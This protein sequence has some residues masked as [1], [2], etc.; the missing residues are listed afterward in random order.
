MAKLD[1]LIV[2]F[3]NN[4]KELDG[5]KKICDSQNANIKELMQADGLSEYVTGDYVARCTISKRESINEDKLLELSNE[6]IALKEA[7]KTKEYI[8]MDILEELIYAGK[9][10]NETLIAM[11][12]CKD[13]KEIT[14]LKVTKKTKKKED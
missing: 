14:T 3:A 13:V 4:K 12:K 9:V 7:I 10:D 5:Y 1:E 2:A 6:H 8:D 11:D